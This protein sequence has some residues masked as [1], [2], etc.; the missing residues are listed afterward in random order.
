MFCLNLVTQYIETS[1]P[2]V[3]QS[4]LAHRGCCQGRARW[5]DGLQLLDSDGIETLAEGHSRE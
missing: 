4:L 3:Q 1:F 5:P 2:A